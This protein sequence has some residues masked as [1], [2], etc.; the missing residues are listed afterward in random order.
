M[1]RR[2]LFG[3]ILLIVAGSA[4][5]AIY[6][7][8]DAQGTRHYSDHA[9]ADNAEQ[10]QLPGLQAADGNADAL[11]ELQAQAASAAADRPTN[12][13]DPRALAFTQP[14]AGQTLRNTQGQVPVALT[15][16]DTSALKSGEKITYS[17]DGKAIPDMPTTQTRLT[18]SRV[19]RGTHTLSAALLYRGRE[20]QRTQPL[21]FHMRAPSAVSPLQTGQS[22]GD[23]GQGDVPGAAVAPPAGNANG[24]MAAPGFQ[25]NSGAAGS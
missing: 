4:P 6:T 16:G 24:A 21:I 23:D 14:E 25:S 8:V 11:R 12:T 22:G 18:L 15:I 19:Q 20:I 17:L 3:L 1:N 9:A 2:V 10:A 7:W 13:G 5:A